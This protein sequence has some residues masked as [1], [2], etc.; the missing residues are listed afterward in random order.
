[1][2]QKHSRS[3]GNN[4]ATT[5]IPL[6]HGRSG[7]DEEDDYE[8]LNRSVWP[9]PF[10]TSDPNADYE[11]FY[12]Y[13]DGSPVVVEPENPTN[14][15]GLKRTCEE[16]DF[17]CSMDG[18]ISKT[19]VCNGIKASAAGGYFFGLKINQSIG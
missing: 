17:R 7:F 10:P 14:S 5:T 16:E 12:E 1:M 9:P 18:C 11:Y 4:F 15:Y 2:D 8:E 6:L 13:E 3:G 19:Q